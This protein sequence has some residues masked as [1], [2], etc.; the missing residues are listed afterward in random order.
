[1]KQIPPEE[2]QVNLDHAHD[3]TCKNNTTNTRAQSVL[4]YLMLNGQL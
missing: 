3:V 4:S 1:M 2:N